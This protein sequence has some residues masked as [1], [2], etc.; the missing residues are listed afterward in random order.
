MFDIS[1]ALVNGSSDLTLRD[2][3][4]YDETIIELASCN[5]VL[6]TV[7]DCYN[8]TLN[9]GRSSRRTRRRQRIR[10]RRPQR[11]V[12]VL[13]R[14]VDWHTRHHRQLRVCRQS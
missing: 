4:I 11:P 8:A 7:G 3:N 9:I 2:V 1:Y 10:R 13:I 12:S 5:P 6:T 14:I